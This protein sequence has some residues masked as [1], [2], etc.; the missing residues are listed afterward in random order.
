MRRWRHWVIE[1]STSLRLGKFVDGVLTLRTLR[2]HALELC[3]ESFV[4][5]TGNI[6]EIDRRLVQTRQGLDV[7][8]SKPGTLSDVVEA[9]DP[10]WLGL[11]TT[12][13]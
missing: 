11:V 3:Q 10:E 8:V 7:Q 5:W 13:Y 1:T 4:M 6:G 2:I 12:I 9:P